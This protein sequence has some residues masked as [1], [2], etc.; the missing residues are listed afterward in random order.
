MG[1]EDLLYLLRLCLKDKPAV[2][3]ELL[4]DMEKTKSNQDAFEKLCALLEDGK[5]ISQANINIAAAK[6]LRHQQRMNTKILSLL[7]IYTAQGSLDADAAKMMNVLGHG[8]E[9][10][11]AMMAAKMKGA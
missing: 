5:N 10:L 1:N 6:A 7:I 8:E 3:K 2:L 9:A 4:V 11:Q